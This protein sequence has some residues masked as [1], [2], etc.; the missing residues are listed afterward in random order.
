[1]LVIKQNKTMEKN[2]KLLEMACGH[3][4]IDNED[5]SLLEMYKELE[6]LNETTLAVASMRHACE[7]ATACEAME[8]LTVTEV[9]E[10]INILYKDFVRVANNPEEYG[11]KQGGHSYMPPS[12]GYID[13]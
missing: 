2:T 9:L 4:L 8:D 13:D 10:S 12:A 5:I 11:G 7:K 3:F 6:I 1:M